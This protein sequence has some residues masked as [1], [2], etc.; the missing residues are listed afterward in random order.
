M[1][2]PKGLEMNRGLGVLVL[3]VVLFQ[4]E[5]ARAQGPGSTSTRTVVLAGAPGGAASAKPTLRVDIIP[6]GVEKSIR[7]DGKLN[8]PEWA[9]A[10]SISKL[11]QIEPDE[12]AAPAGRTVVRVLASPTGLVFGVRCEED[13]SAFVAFS[14]ARDIELD[15]EDHFLLLLDTFGDE[16]SGYVFG[17]NM[18][19]SRFDGLINAQ[20][21]DVNSSWDA[22]WEAAVSRDATGWTAEVRIPL[23]SLTFKNGLDHWGF[24]VER[25]VQSLQ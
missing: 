7:L 14:K 2:S 15:E 21:D 12:G 1:D 3:L 16:R 10:D 6:A 5:P 4:G 18:L 8:D 20:G 19:G 24:N 17:V 23:Q 25:R 11:I 9:T 13:S 22:L